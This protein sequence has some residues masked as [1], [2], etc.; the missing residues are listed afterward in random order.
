MKKE[1]E[2]IPMRSLRRTNTIHIDE[3]K[4]DDEE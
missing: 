4:H 2:K 1:V 3:P